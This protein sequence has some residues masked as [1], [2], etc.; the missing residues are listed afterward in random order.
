MEPDLEILLPAFVAGVLIVA[1]HVPLGREVL[2]RGIIFI[3]LA[4]A[5]IA[6]L[7]VILARSLEWT[8][9][10]VATQFAAFG[11][12]IAGSIILYVCERRWPEIQEAIIGTTFVLTAATALLLLSHNPHGGEQ[13]QELLSGQI[14]WVS[15]KQV[16][17]VA[18]LYLFVLIAW[19]KLST[20]RGISFY[21]LFAITVTASVQLVGVLLVFASLVV[22]ALL[23]RKFEDRSTLVWAYGHSVFAYLAGFITSL[24]FD[25]PAGPTI[26]WALVVVGLGLSY[27]PRPIANDGSN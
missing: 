18:V 23:V 15:W 21:L 4:V 2:N 6:V 22:P 5:Q 7:G 9:A 8:E 10:D 3:D 25:L 14:L 11:S 12:A 1:T 20:H 19:S 24:L 17:Y 16:A 13:L 27:L 26:V